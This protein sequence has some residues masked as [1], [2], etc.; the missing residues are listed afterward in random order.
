V[1]AQ[2][3]RFD[4]PDR[5]IA[6]TVG[7]PGE[8]SFFLQA[9]DATKLISVLLEKEQV[10]VL[11]ERVDDMLD[12]ILRRAGGLTSVPAVAPAELEDLDPL[13][14]PIVEEFR[15]GSM[16]L[17]WDS[18]DEHV[19]VAAYAVV[20]DDSE[21]PDDPEESDRDVMV[22]RLSG[23]EA[24]AFVKRAQALVAAGRPPCP[25]CSLPLD[26]SGHVC[27]RQNGYRRRG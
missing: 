4:Q 7:R 15:V 26:P 14:Q 27:P 11:A 9:R 19:E 21:P 22:V 5:F 2:V 16:T 17:K 25:L 10:S 3:Y 24:R 6:G 12:E 20:D 13:E 8:R 23:A 18:E 1:S